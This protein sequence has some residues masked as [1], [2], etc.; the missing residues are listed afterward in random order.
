MKKCL[1]EGCEQKVRAKGMCSKHYYRLKNTGSLETKRDTTTWKS[2]KGT[3]E[4]PGCKNKRKSS[5]LCNTHYKQKLKYGKPGSTLLSNKGVCSIEGCEKGA[6]AKGMCTTHYLRNYK[7][8]DPNVLIKG[9]NIGNCSV[10]NERIA[11]AKGMCGRCYH[12]W[13]VSSDQDFAEK[14]AAR[15]NRRRAAK[16]ESESERYTKS[17]VIEEKGK[18]CAL[19][20]ENIDLL[21]KYPNPKSFTIDHIIPISKGGSDTINNVQPAHFGCN[22]SKRD[23]LQENL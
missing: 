2:S 5:G 20:G 16:N 7:H 3:C 12:R 23:K 8:G 21:L 14:M 6:Y 10:C 4:F 15:N 19:C 18:I 22:S 11:K 1:I 9:H 17:M 13:K